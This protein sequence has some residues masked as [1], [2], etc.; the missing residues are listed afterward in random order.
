MKTCFLRSPHATCFTFLAV[1]LTFAS[2]A[3]TVRG[4]ETGLVII[5]S[6][7]TLQGNFARAQLIVTRAAAE[8]AIDDRSEDLTSA[9]KYVS[10]NPAVVGV[11]E[12]GRL[13]LASPSGARFAKSP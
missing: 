4:D 7:V 12:S 2:T 8:A 5:P 10:S 9:A 3:A 6:E 13:K 11:S 1:L